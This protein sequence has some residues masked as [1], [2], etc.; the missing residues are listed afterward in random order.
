[1]RDDDT[2][3]D[4]DDHYGDWQ[5]HDH[6]VMRNSDDDE[7]KI[8]EK[9]DSAQRKKYKILSGSKK[10]FNY[11]KKQAEEMDEEI[12]FED[13]GD[14]LVP[15]IDPVDFDDSLIESA[16]SNG[17]AAGIAAAISTPPAQ[18]RYVKQAIEQHPGS[19]PPSAASRPASNRIP[20]VM[21]IG[22]NQTH[23]H[24]DT[25]FNENHDHPSS[26]T[27]SRRAESGHNHKDTDFIEN[28]DR[29]S[30]KKANSRRPESGR[31]AHK[32]QG[33][34]TREQ[35]VHD[36]DESHESA[37]DNSKQKKHAASANSRPNSAGYLP[38]N[39]FSTAAASRPSSANL[40]NFSVPD[41]NALS[42][43]EPGI[44][45]DYDKEPASADDDIFA[46]FFNPP[47]TKRHQKGAADGNQRGAA[48]GNDLLEEVIQHCIVVLLACQ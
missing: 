10:K 22:A 34:S 37:V 35:V 41:F 19:R 44:I 23:H 31:E 29:P 32:N 38:T 11:S 40:E 6:K 24:K 3:T 1:M 39:P 12:L 42:S 16:I 46:A 47:S 45:P 48:D 33:K 21:H 20:A 36:A 18:R 26:K 8:V 43:L 14:Q 13:P 5:L 25:D 27:T 17:T 28:H 15:N 4:F 2:Q 7:R 9:S 30:S